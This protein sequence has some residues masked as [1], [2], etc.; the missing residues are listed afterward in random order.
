VGGGTI[1]VL[2]ARHARNRENSATDGGRA[3]TLDSGKRHKGDRKK[4]KEK[5]TPLSKI[6]RGRKRFRQR[7]GG[8]YR[9][10]GDAGESSEEKV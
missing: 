5:N 6:G 8:E 3:V 7:E 4:K 1:A 9:S 10:H 2:H